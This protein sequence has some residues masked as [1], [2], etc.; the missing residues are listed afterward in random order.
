[1]DFLQTL[2]EVEGKLRRG[3]GQLSS[4]KVDFYEKYIQN[5]KQS[6]R[7]PSLFKIGNLL[8]SNSLT[9]P[10]LIP[11]QNLKGIAFELN[12]TN[13]EEIHLCLQHIAL[14]IIHQL[15]PKLCKVT[16]IDPKKMG[17]NFRFIRK[18]SNSSVGE[19]IYDEEGI[20]KNINNHFEKSISIINECLIHYANL[21]DYNKDTDGSQPYRFVFIADFPYGFR[22]C[23]DKLST[24]I[25]NNQ[26]AGIFFFMTYDKSLSL[27]MRQE[28]VN[29]ILSELTILREYGDPAN[30]FYNIEN[31]VNH[32]FYNKD[33]TL[34][35]D[36]RDINPDN[37][38]RLISQTTIESKK[39]VNDELSDGLRIP[40]GK[41]AGRTHYFTIG[42]ETDNYHGIIGGQPGKGKTVLLNNIIA[43]GIE[44]Y[45]PDEL[46][47]ILLDCAGVGFQEFKESNH[48]QVLRSSSKVEECVEVIKKIEEELDRREALFRDARVAELK[49]YLKKTGKPLPRLLCLIDEFHVL[50]TGGSRTG[51]YVETILV[52]R[53]I[54]IGRKFGVHLIV[55]TQSLGGGVRRSILDNIPLRIA[56]GMTPDQS[57][58]F[59]GFKNE[60]AGNL[61]RGVAIYNNQNGS[62]RANKTVRVNYIDYNAVERAVKASNQ[63]YSEYEAFEQQI[64]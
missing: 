31:I 64:F 42:H 12:S 33:F 38:N 60:A 30:D 4:P 47:F 59:L 35:L 37:L 14:Q 54:R 29:E 41:L 63:K 16:I 15:D 27:G 9:F 62:S 36:R 28:K 5:N 26:E 21:D 46:R 8:H 57:A 52:E 20:K 55:S 50:F 1:M 40:I 44:S 3:M 7:L 49:D 56:L 11:M 45:S 10:A 34:Q 58:G 43:R 24:L 18:L 23:I 13:R 51:A 48:V 22:D 19:L 53:V 32:N 2:R 6:S 61:E 17:S 39:Q 25:H